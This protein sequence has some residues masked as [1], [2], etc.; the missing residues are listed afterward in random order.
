VLDELV[1]ERGGQR[2]AVIPLV[3]QDDLREGDRREVL[4][5]RHVHD[6]DLPARPDQLFEL[7]ERDV[8]ALLRV[9]ELAIR[10]A[11]DDV[12]HDRS[13]SSTAV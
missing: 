11:L 2:G 10:V 4:A 8:T 3:L 6:R 7:L 5:G 1:Q 13:Q 9:V 12:R